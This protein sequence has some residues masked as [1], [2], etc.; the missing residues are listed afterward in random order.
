MNHFNPNAEGKARQIT[1][2]R[3]K[4]RMRLKYIGFFSFREPL[5]SEAYIFYIHRPPR[6]IR[7]S[8]KQFANVRR[9]FRPNI[10]DVL[11]HV[12]EQLL[13]EVRSKFC[14]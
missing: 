2:I 3:E 12:S 13:R 1:V 6:G 14:T 8:A 11:L 5:L 10:L 9:I 4:H 7:P